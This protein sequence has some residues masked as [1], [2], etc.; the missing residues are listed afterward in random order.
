MLLADWSNILDKILPDECVEQVIC[1]QFV[2]P[3]LEALGF[4]AQ[5]RRPQFKTGNSADKVDFAAR[6][7]KDNDIFFNSQVNPYLLVEVKARATGAG[8]KINLA[9]DTPQY[10]ATR[11]QIKK[12]LLA[13]NCQTAQW[14]IITN[15]VH[16]QLFRRHGRVVIPATNNEIIKKDNITDIITKIKNL[17]ENPPKALTICV[18]NNKGGVGKTTTTINLAAILKKEHKKVLLVDFDSQRDLTKSLKLE[19][20]SV[21][22]FDCLTDK[23][24]DVRKTVVPFS[25]VGKKGKPVH[26]F[27]V[28]P[29]DIRMEKYTDTNV[30][31]TIQKGSARLRYLLKN[32]LYDYDYIII[33]CPTQWLFFSQSSIYASD[34][35]LIPTKHNGSTSLYNAARVIK[36]FIPEVKKARSDGGPMALPIFFNGE[37]ITDPQLKLTNGE[38]EKIIIQ[39][40]Q[41]GVNLLPYYWP[42]ATPGNVDKTIFSIPSY[43]TVANAVFSHVP[44]VLLNATVEQHYLGFAKEYFLYG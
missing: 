27:D 15:G 5:E 42:K 34:V 40:K 25:P 35:I 14:G 23:N 3:L 12:Y 6:Y 19:V 24:L 4:N 11:Q 38:I 16:I 7:N 1:N 36:E 30:A 21:S 18:Y 33:D 28:I 9:E 39:A 22:L 10:L 20:G 32:F 37:K 31:A 29:S 41:S 44:A 8:N 43:A 2:E 26:L 17:I 13:P